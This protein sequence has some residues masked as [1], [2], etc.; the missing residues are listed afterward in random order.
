M[1]LLPLANF[2]HECDKNVLTNGANLMTFSTEEEELD[3]FV[4]D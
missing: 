1:L 3:D 2:P 4:G